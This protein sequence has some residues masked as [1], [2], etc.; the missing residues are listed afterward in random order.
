[1]PTGTRKNSRPRQNLRAAG[2]SSGRFTSVAARGNHGSG[3]VN[4][5]RAYERY[6]AL[7][8]AAALSG[9]TVESEN[10]YQHAEHYFRLMKGQSFDETS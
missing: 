10:C 5:K 9:D 3:P 7:A 2:S 6:L 4:A 1:M 8:H